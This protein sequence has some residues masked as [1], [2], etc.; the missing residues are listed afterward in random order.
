MTGMTGD[1]GQQVKGA[2]KKRR[3]IEFDDDTYLAMVDAVAKAK[4]LWPRDRPAQLAAIAAV[5]LEQAADDLNRS[6]T[7]LLRVT[8]QLR[9]LTIV[10]LIVAVLPWLSALWRLIFRN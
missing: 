9:A 7:V 2:T 10:L 6:T 1:S 8:I 4:D 3:R 5:R